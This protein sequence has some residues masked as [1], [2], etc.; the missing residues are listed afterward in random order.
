MHTKSHTY[1]RHD[2]RCA[3]HRMCSYCLVY[4]S[5]TQTSY[6]CKFL[7][8]H[9]L[10][11]PKNM[12]LLLLYGML[13]YKRTTVTSHF[14]IRTTVTVRFKFA[15]VNKCVAVKL[16]FQ[17]VYNNDITLQVCTT[18][19]SHFK[20]RTTVTVRFKFA[21]VNKC[22][23]VAHTLQDLYNSDMT[24]QDSY[25]SDISLQDMYHSDITL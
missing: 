23:A 8:S 10:P 6:T 18:V 4:L 22:A 15:D 7:T 14:K 17:D 24:L 13:V 3:G 2:I 5:C 25:H 20:I 12:T 19:T 16:H 11:S 9:P 1:N 21:D